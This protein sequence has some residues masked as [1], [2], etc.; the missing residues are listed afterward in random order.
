MKIDNRIAE[1]EAKIEGLKE[2]KEVAEKWRAQVL[3]PQAL[4]TQE[5]VEAFDAFHALAISYMEE[6]AAGNPES[7]KYWIF[8]SVMTK[9]LGPNVW[10]IINVMA[11]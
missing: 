4:T 6:E 5:K 3:S 2:A 7:D 11:R 8:E 9:C 10:A 1:L